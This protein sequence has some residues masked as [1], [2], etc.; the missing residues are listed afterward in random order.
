MRKMR[1]CVSEAKICK[2]TRRQGIDVSFLIW[3]GRKKGSDVRRELRTKRGRAAGTLYRASTCS[4]ALHGTRSTVEGTAR[5]A[6]GGRWHCE[7][8]GGGDGIVE[9]VANGIGPQSAWVHSWPRTAALFLRY[10]N[11][12]LYGVVQYSSWSTLYPP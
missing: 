12:I 5:W 10:N 1:P 9:G 4:G 6:G 7:S 2:K 11:K 8:A 3:K